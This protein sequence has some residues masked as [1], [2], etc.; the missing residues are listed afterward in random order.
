M[1][2]Y[3]SVIPPHNPLQGHPPALNAEQRNDLFDVLDQAPKM[4]LDEIQDWMA[5]HHD[6][7]I[8][9]TS[10]HWV[11]QDAGLSLKMLHKAASERD[12]EA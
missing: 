7:A 10:L 4:F 3:G 8:S 6:A 2:L 9:I 11:I 12:E 5:L 1:D